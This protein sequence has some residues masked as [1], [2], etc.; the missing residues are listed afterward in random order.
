M[1]KP[2]NMVSVKNAEVVVKTIK[3]DLKAKCEL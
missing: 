2:Y 3:S 1:L